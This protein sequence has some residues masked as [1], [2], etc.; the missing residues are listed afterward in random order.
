MLNVKKAYT[1]LCGKVEQLL[2]VAKQRIEELGGSIQQLEGQKRDLELVAVGGRQGIR[3]A[4]KTL[5]QQLIQKEEEV[6]RRIE[7]AASETKQNL[8]KHA[9][10]TEEKIR[11]LQESQDMLQQYC[12]DGHDV[13]AL[14]WYA[15]AKHTMDELL[16]RKEHNEHDP[17]N[18]NANFQQFQEIAG[19]LKGEVQ[20]HLDDVVGIGGQISRLRAAKMRAGAHGPEGVSVGGGG[21]GGGDARRRHTFFGGANQAQ[22]SKAFLG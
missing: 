21:G 11:T 20:R 16:T 5:R 8:E 1:N 13:Q 9:P 6:L 10:A 15:T 19:A 2:D 22:D 7:E 14:N 17:H 12:H 18:L 3:D 4:F